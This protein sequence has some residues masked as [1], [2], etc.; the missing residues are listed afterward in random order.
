MKSDIFTALTMAILTT[1]DTISVTLTIFFRTLAFFA[2]TYYMFL[3]L[4]STISLRLL[5][6]PTAQT[7]A[8][9]STDL[10]IFETNTILL[11]TISIDTITRKFLYI[12][13]WFLRLNETIC[14]IY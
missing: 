11:S 4:K 9:F 8:F 14:G 7:S 3:L 2:V 13:H 5:F 6:I 12:L 10:T 1:F